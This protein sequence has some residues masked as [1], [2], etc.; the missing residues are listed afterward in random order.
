MAVWLE[1]L[2]AYSSVPKLLEWKMTMATMRES[3]HKMMMAMM[4]E[5]EMM[6]ETD[7]KTMLG[8]KMM[9]AMTKETDAKTLLD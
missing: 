4:K 1:I 6:K 3:D 9:T 5:L 2:L 8:L 7:A